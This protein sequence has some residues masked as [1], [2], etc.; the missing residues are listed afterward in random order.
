MTHRC[1]W[2]KV[3]EQNEQKELMDYIAVDKKIGKDVTGATVVRTM[4]EGL[5]HYAVC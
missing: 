4:F 3:N 2:R 1:T 5:H